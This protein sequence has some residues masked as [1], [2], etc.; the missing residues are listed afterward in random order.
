MSSVKITKWNADKLLKRVPFVLARYGTKVTPMLQEQIKAKVYQW[1]FPTTRK[2]GLYSG[3]YVPAGPRDI[4]DTGE[5]L[6]S[7]SAPQITENSL[8]IR[9]G[10]PYSGEVLRGRYLIGTVRTFYVAPER[11]WIT[12]VLKAEPPLQF[13]VNEWRKL[14]GA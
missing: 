10:A 4:V 5:L 7:Q 3:K 6:R 12:P 14:S 8:T 9:W 1:D 13:F 2:V 11:D